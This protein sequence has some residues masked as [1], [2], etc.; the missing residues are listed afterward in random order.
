VRVAA[1]IS[2][3][4]IVGFFAVFAMG[5]AARA[6]MV[7]VEPD[8]F[9]DGETITNEFVTLR[10]QTLDP[11]QGVLA[12]DGSAS[13]GVRVF[14]RETAPGAAS[15]LITW[16]QFRAGP[17]LVSAALRA[18]FVV[19]ADFVSIDVIAGDNK[20]FLLEAYDSSGTLLESTNPSLLCG[21]SSCQD[22]ETRTVSIT[23]PQADIS[24]ILAFGPGEQGGGVRLDNLTL[25]LSDLI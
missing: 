19:P 24:Y 17:S 12:R 23:R 5:G 8:D 16:G 10:N 15:N 1:A 14:G 18:N 6:D 7:I 21:Q 20:S 11:N 4:L 3:W 2:T 9:N 25:N 13:T 22:E